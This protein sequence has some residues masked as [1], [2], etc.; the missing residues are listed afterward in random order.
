MDDARKQLVF[1]L[2]RVLFTKCEKI[3]AA[4]KMNTKSAFSINRKD[5]RRLR[6]R[7]DT[8]W[9]QHK[10]AFGFTKREMQYLHMFF[11]PLRIPYWLT[12]DQAQFSLILYGAIYPG[13]TLIRDGNLEILSKALNSELPVLEDDMF[14]NYLR[15]VLAEKIGINLDAKKSDK[16]FERLKALPEKD[17]KVVEEHMRKILGFAKTL[18]S[19]IGT[20]PEGEKA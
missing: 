19:A 13:E 9:R 5:F 6:R 10:R 16:F 1:V 4:R 20:N 11:S 7:Q 12:K 3:L 14:R 2:T 18:K 8:V 15:R 17:R